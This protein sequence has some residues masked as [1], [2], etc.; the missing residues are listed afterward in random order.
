MTPSEHLYKTLKKAGIDFVVSVPC[1]KLEQLILLAESDQE[2]TYTPVTREEEGVGI[3][4]GAALAG[5][6]PAILMQNSGL[7]NSLNAICSLVG[8]YGLPIFMVISHRGTEGETIRAQIPMGE[9]T[10]RILEAV[11]IRHLVID[12]VGDLP[13]AESL[14]ASGLQNSVSAALLFPMSFWDEKE[15]QR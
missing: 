8:L 3:L 12:K 2:I 5:K 11:G 6:R 9:A 1:V 13:K 15:P 7:G 10:G 14:I 4:A